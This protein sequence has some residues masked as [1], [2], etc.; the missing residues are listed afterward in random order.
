MFVIACPSS[1]YLCLV[2][3]RRRRF[4][5]SFSI[6]SLS[7]SLRRWGTPNP[8]FGLGFPLCSL[9]PGHELSDFD[10]YICPPHTF[11]KVPLPHLFFFFVARSPSRCF[12]RVLSCRC[13]WSGW[14][15]VVVGNRALS[16]SPSRPSGAFFGLLVWSGA[17]C[18]VF[19]SPCFLV[20]GGWAG[21]FCCLLHLENSFLHL[22]NPGRKG[23]ALLSLPL[24]HLCLGAVRGKQSLAGS[25]PLGQADRWQWVGE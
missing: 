20:L 25:R 22:G 24:L 10:P 9:H 1:F 2:S 18:R 21:D 5:F 4:F 16:L 17:P 3:F 13:W 15:S 23:P 12:V 7:L 14:V 8:V 19:S 6:L 11:T